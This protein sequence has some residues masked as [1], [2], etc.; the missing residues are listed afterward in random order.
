MAD[1]EA[2]G[3]TTGLGLTVILIVFVP[4]HPAT[5]P[6]KVYTVV[7]VGDTETDDPDRL[8]GIHT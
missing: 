3:V 7:E 8:P 4:L 1:G 2:V 5:V 6:V